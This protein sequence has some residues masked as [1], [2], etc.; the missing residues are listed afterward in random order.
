VAA[1]TGGPGQHWTPG[2]GTLVNTASG[3]CLDDPDYDVTPGTRLEIFAR[4]GGANQQWTL[5]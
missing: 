1:C 2:K 3:R 5:P 4:T